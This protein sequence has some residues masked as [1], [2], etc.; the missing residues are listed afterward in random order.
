MTPATDI[1]AL[2]RAY[3]NLTGLDVALNMDRE[4][5][6]FDWLHYRR[7]DPFTAT[8]LGLVIAHLR[9]GIR[10]EKRNP[11]AL[12]FRN[13]IGNPDEF[14][15]ERAAARKAA[16]VAAKPRPPASVAETVRDAHGS[17]TRI[18]PNAGTQD[19]SRPAGAISEQ[20]LAGLR[21]LK[22]ELK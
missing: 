22:E 1:P 8:D 15:E 14:D 11:G 12:R 19:T 4:R 2:H 20:A 17:T 18:V 3:V 7:D 5:V 21:K 13:L 16:A 9:R 10:D 6:W